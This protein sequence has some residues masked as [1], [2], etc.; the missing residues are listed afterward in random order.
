MPAQSVP[1]AEQRC[2]WYLNDVGLFAHVPFEAVSVWPSR[3]LL[4]PV[5]VGAV[6][7]SGTAAIAVAA[8]RP[9]STTVETSGAIIRFRPVGRAKL[10]AHSSLLSV[11]TFGGTRRR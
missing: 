4:A 6:V 7:L 8:T 3:A 9:A 10:P 5:I 1:A 2:H 11:Q